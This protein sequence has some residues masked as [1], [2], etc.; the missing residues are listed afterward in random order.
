[1]EL[2]R[3]R[4]EATARELHAVAQGATAVGTG[5]NA[6][7]DFAA[8]FVHHLAA[9]TGIAW[10]RAE[11]PF[12]A[13]ASH[14]AIVACSGALDALAA[15]LMKIGNDIRLLGSG[16]RAGIGEL[17]LPENEPG[18]SIMPG[19]VNPTQAEAL[20][21]VCARVIGNHTTIVVAGASGHLQLNVFK[22]V[23]VDALLQSIR[24][25][26]DAATS[27][28]THCVRGIEPR[29]ETLDALMRRSLMLAT[30]LNPHVGY[31][32]AA[33]IAK[34]AHARNIGLREAALELGLVS[35]ADFDR[36]VDPAAMAR[37]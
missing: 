23:I 14:D 30:A 5:L 29:L 3:R 7:P 33:K 18:S 4:I 9:A 34:H 27:F 10:R 8:R 36:W 37:P 21:M 15:G 11:D 16:P 25:L 24:L 2:G 17:A 28:T 22:P 13:L 19:K 32:A 6:H 20:T 35:A 26:A 1:V 12:E 31:D